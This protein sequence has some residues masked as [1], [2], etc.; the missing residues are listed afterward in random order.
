MTDLSHPAPQFSAI[1]AEQ[2][3]KD[4]FGVDATASQLD[5]ERDCNFRL[6]TGTDADWILKIVNASEPKLESEFQTA[7]LHHLS[8]AHSRLAVPR[9]KPSA[10]GDVL[11][12]TTG[13][14]GEKHA[15]RLVGWLPGTPL[16]EVNRTFGLMRNLGRSLGELDQALQGFIHVGALR[17]L[18]WDLRHAG[19]ARDRLHHINDADKKALLERFITRFENFVAPKL[20]GLRAQVIHNDANDWNVLVDNDNHE[21]IAGLID[22]GDAVHTVLIAEVAIACAYAALDTQDP[23]GAAA[24]LAEGFHERYPLQAEEIDLLF[25]LMAMRLVTSVTVSASRREKTDDNPYL[26]ISEAPAWRLLEKMDAMNPRF[27]TAIL[28]K[29]CGF[30]AIDG[31]GAIRKWVSDNA[32][33]FAPIVRPAPATLKKAIVPYGDASHFMTVA[34][35]E[36]RATE[37]TQWWDDFCAQNDIELG[38]GSW[39][40]KRTVY[41]DKAFQSRFIEGQRRIHHLGV[42][43]FMPAGTPLYT[44]LAATVA[45]VEIEHEPL[46]YG[47]LVKLEHHPE[48]CPPFVTLWGHMA[49]EA[50]GRLKTGQKLQPGDLVGHMGDIDENGGWTPHLHFEMTTDVNLT[51]TEIL[52]VGEA[53]YLK[54]WADLFPDVADL[55]GIPPETFAQEGRSRGEI[56]ERRKDVLLPNLSISYS[57]PI[58]FVRGDGAWLIDDRGRAYLDCFNNVCHIGHA[59]PEVVDAIARQAGL[60]NTNTRYLHDNIVEYAERLTATL[61]E[62]LTVASFACSGSEANSLALRMARNHTGRNEAIVLD[63]AYHGTTQELIDLSPYKYKRKGGKGRPEH[64]YEGRIP[65][66]YR[67]PQDWP[68]EDHGKRFAEDI[69]EKIDSMRHQGKAPSFFLA[70]SIPSVAGQVFLPEGYLKQVYA[71]VRAAGGVCIAD[72]VQVGFGRVGS[73]WWA[74]E[75]QDV[76]PDIVT[77]GKP[78]GNGHPM[79]AVVTTREIADSFNNGM[80]YFNTFGGNPVSCAAGL[81]VLN[82]IERDGL[83]ENALDVGNY[84]IDGFRKMQN[85][86]EIIGDVRGQG[87]FLGIELVTDRKTKTPA[88]DL[89][90]RIN[91]G[92]RQRGILMGTEG[93]YDNVL[94]MRPSMVFSRQNADHLLDVLN[95]SFVSA[96]K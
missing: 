85:R 25:D 58:K 78:I 33:T 91:D 16:A 32:K 67:A 51:A 6:K 65:D 46:G 80:E 28:R 1:D 55:A 56:I 94:K 35:A 68:F 30:D 75:L 14:S 43:L 90:R 5:S 24:A 50:L 83:R 44:P 87:L 40:E 73:H 79:S 49:H 17:D 29:A 12:L 41:T 71:M 84:L 66:S 81:A 76:V 22:F 11:A 92:A 53:A 3:A 18:D 64:V 27:A 21:K 93:P 96:L 77:M 59:H 36:Q 19:R 42:D 15:L 4:V 31:A 26:A 20:A 82:V 63:W 13:K 95:D 45:S 61:P 34:S 54:V 37:A 72:E 86:F 74:F 9:L 39:G 7:L 8:A 10:S 38:I 62:G 89:A 88:T 2:L 47:G 70:E 48:N 23:I 57:E 69:A 52:G 60:L